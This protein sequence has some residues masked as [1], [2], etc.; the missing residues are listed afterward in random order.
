[1]KRH[2]KQFHN[3]SEADAMACYQKQKRKADVSSCELCKRQVKWLSNHMKTAHNTTLRALRTQDYADT[4]SD[5]LSSSS[6]SSSYSPSSS[7]DD[8]DDK[9]SGVGSKSKRVRPNSLLRNYHSRS[10]S[11]F[12]VPQKRRQSFPSKMEILERFKDFMLSTD[13]G[14]AK[15]TTVKQYSGCVG[16][17]I[18]KGLGGKFSTLGEVLPALAQPGGY[19]ERLAENHCPKTVKNHFF[20]LARFLDFLNQTGVNVFSTHDDSLKAIA[21]VKRWSESYRGKTATQT[22][23]FNRDEETRVEAVAKM[24]TNYLGS[25]HHKQALNIIAGIDTTL[26]SPLCL[27][28]FLHVRNYLMMMIFLLNGNRPGVVRNMTLKEVTP[29]Q[30]KLLPESTAAIIYVSQHKTA[31]TYGDARIVLDGEVLQHLQI[32]TFV[33]QK[34]FTPTQQKQHDDNKED[35]LFSNYQ[36]AKISSSE[37]ARVL[38]KIMHS[39]GMDAETAILQTP[40]RMRK[41]HYLLQ[42][43]KGDGLTDD[44][45]VRMAKH[46]MHS[47]KTARSHYDCRNRDKN[48]LAVFEQLKATLTTANSSSNSTATLPSLP[49]SSSSSASSV[50]NFTGSNNNNE[51]EDASDTTENAFITLMPPP[52]MTLTAS[53]ASLPLTPDSPPSL[54]LPLTTSLTAA[55]TTTTSPPSSP[56]FPSSSPNAVLVA[57]SGSVTA[58]AADSVNELTAEE[59]PTLSSSPGNSG[60]RMKQ[61]DDSQGTAM[62]EEDPT[63]MMKHGRRAG[64]TKAD[65]KILNDEFS[66]FK[67]PPKKVDVMRNSFT[68]L[69]VCGMRF[70]SKQIV[71]RLRYM[72]RAKAKSNLK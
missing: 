14:L 3:M 17:L 37:P 46:L 47:A 1:M 29:P 52:P 20:A 4:E 65:V 30:I 62:V 5:F 11:C 24:M 59:R 7:D 61:G 60:E 53:S 50:D 15:A 55:T 70:T 67:N 27:N 34:L 68:N 63:T 56:L 38:Q 6:S 23:K 28:D 19:Y 48:S 49:P 39:I 72:F 71:D 25:E 2:L 26:F 10:L 40:T 43:A 13:G 42:D 69:W 64:F 16:N 57:T 58:D 12:F 41:G 31:E 33:R 22:A 66:H 36:G 32:F 45:L 21:R 8:D 9:N 35:F 44:S 54:L 51:L 18:E